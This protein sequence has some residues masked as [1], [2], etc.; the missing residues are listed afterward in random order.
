MRRTTTTAIGFLFVLTCALMFQF[1]SLADYLDNKL[2][3]QQFRFLRYV[4][5]KTAK[6]DVVIVGIDEG[7]FKTFPEPLALWHPHLGKFFAAL[8]EAKPLVVGL[9]TVLP[10]RSFDFLLSGYDRPLLAGLLKLKRTAP[11]FLALPIGDKDKDDIP[12]FAPIVSIAGK[13]AFGMVLVKADADKTIRRFESI[14]ETDQGADPTLVGRMLAHLGIKQD[15][16]II[17]YSVGKPYTYIPLQKV[18]KWYDAGEFDLLK[19][20]FAGK[21]V[22]LGP[23]LF[24]D[25]HVLPVSL[26]AWEPGE[27]LLPGV[28]IHAQALRSFQQGGLIHPTSRLFIVL[29]IVV[30]S[31][32]W[33]IGDRPYWGVPLFA[34]LVTLL[35]A[36]SAYLLSAGLFLP[37]TAI[38][39]SSSLGLFG[40]MG[41][42]GVLAF[43][44]KRRLRQSFGSYVSPNV[45]QEILAGKI[46][47]GMTGS[48]KHLCVLFSDI[49][50]FT[51]RSES[52]TPEATISLLNRYFDEMTATIHLHGGTIDK[53][54]G[55]GLMAFFGAPNSRDNPAQDAFDAAR[56][57]L[58]RLEE[59]NKQ[60][61]AQGIEPIRIGVGLDA[62][63]VIVG[64]VGSTS[65]NEY[66]V[67]GDTVNVASRL[68]GLTKVVGYPIVCTSDVAG[69]LNGAEELDALGEQAIA[70][71]VPVEVFSW[72]PK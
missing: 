33:W 15:N 49:R 34:V 66:T 50:G 68:E 45:L 63:E 72:R 12:F 44:E 29:L 2:M 20:T 47:P 42:E 53:F 43:R 5:P 62:G 6:S 71:H 58:K 24:S 35:L 19:R 39:V 7:T 69:A 21:P 41:L 51:K 46:S 52:Q 40:R 64:H 4:A 16:G 28:L 48:R 11:V 36:Y 8:A 32:L 9:D 1:T 10:N 54:M 22:L 67:I 13:E 18:I 27:R 56:E 31:L 14:L 55:D 70:G 25:R 60:L 61:S 3:D 17:D 57:M 65:R 26:A 59:L 38:A 23:I 37:V 30:A